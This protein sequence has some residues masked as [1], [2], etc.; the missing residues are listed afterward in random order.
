MLRPSLELSEV[1]ERFDLGKAAG[2]WQLVEGGLSNELLRLKTNRGE[3][4]VKRMLAG[5][6]RS[7]FEATVEASF[8][9]ERAAVCAG[10]P[11]P[12]PI[13]PKDSAGCLARIS[14]EDGSEAWVRVH[15]W[16]EGRPVRPTEMSETVARQLGEHIAR[17]HGLDVSALGEAEPAT[18]LDLAH[19]AAL[20]GRGTAENLASAS[21]L[22]DLT[23]VLEDLGLQI[24]KRSANLPVPGH[25]DADPKNVLVSADRTVML[26]D[27]DAAGPIDAGQELTALMLDWVGAEVSIEA[28]AIGRAVRIGYRDAVGF[29]PN[30][31]ASSWVASQFGWL[32]YNVERALGDHGAEVIDLGVREIEQTVA[33]LSR[34]GPVIP[35]LLARWRTL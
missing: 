12:L 20:T 1:C 31:D 11:A 35:E 23:P 22:R 21:T 28:S 3:Y 15:E 4:A 6:H 34:I 14:C 32:T 16:V 13:S 30:L 2:P 7:E 17:V 8:R 29:V 5:T 27:W 24:T 19:W 26:L 33:R 9:V 25:R 18:P 10:I